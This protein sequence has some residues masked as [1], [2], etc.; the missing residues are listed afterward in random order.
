MPIK[1]KN[2]NTS[3]TIIKKINGLDTIPVRHAVLRKGKPIE[4]CAIPQ[5]NLE[6]T[7]HFGVFFQDKLVGVCTFVIDKSSHFNDAK[8]YRLRAMG[9]L[10]DY[11]GYKFGQ[12]LL[13]YGVTF[14]KEKKIER[15]WFNARIIAVDFYKNNGFKTIGDI[16]NIPS[17]GDHCIMH[18][19]L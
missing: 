7:F 9:I 6:S 18:K 8:Q 13:A 5:D 12:K 10:D 2:I 15:L 4:A 11:Q 19:K 16:F 14:L 3:T 17:I 1:P